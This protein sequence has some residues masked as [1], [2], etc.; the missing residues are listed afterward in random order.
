M[1]N[2]TS[3]DGFHDF[4]TFEQVFIAQQYRIVAIWEVTHSF[5]LS[6]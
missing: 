6:S 2:L 3:T 4:A 1:P 5:W